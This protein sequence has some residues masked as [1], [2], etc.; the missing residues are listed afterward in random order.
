MFFFFF[1][2]IYYKFDALLH[3]ILYGI[4]FLLQRKARIS[5][6]C[7]CV[8]KH[9]AMINNLS[10]VNIRWTIAEPS[11]SVILSDPIRRE[12]FEWLTK[13][14]RIEKKN[15]T[16]HIRSFWFYWN[17]NRKRLWFWQRKK[18]LKRVK[19]Y[20]LQQFHRLEIILANRNSTRSSHR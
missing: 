10:V 9:N 7:R 19:N 8:N 17:V 5:K 18:R 14:V 20:N 15:I 6:Q 1:F 3:Y 2:V 16:T 13:N 12:R 4:G 11:T